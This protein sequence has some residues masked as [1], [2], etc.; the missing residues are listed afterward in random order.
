MVAQIRYS[1]REAGACAIDALKSG[2][3]DGYAT[4]SHFWLFQ[5]LCE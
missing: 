2:R 1:F 5:S 3:I 4:L